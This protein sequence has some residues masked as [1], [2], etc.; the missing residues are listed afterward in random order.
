MAV[1]GTTNSI[2]Y[3]MDKS[4]EIRE[5]LYPVIDAI[6]LANPLISLRQLSLEVKKRTGRGAMQTV[7]DRYMSNRR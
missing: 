7:R 3:Q 6:Q 2:K 1:K 4:K 5:N